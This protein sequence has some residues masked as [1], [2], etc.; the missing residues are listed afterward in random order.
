MIRLT[1][2]QRLFL[3][4]LLN[5]YRETDHPVRYTE[6]AEKLGVNPVTAYE[7]LRLL[8]EKGLVTS[9]YIRPSGHLGRSILVFRPTEKAEELFNRLAGEAGSEGEWEK[10]KESILRA[11]EEG[12]GTNYEDL[13]DQI[14]L[15]IPECKSPLLYT[16][17]MVTA[18]ILMLYRIRDTAAARGIFPYLRWLGPPGWI[19]LHTLAGLSLGLSMAEKVNR[20]F[21]SK[22][23]SYSQ[24]FQ[25]HLDM[26]TG[27]EK[28]CLSDFAGEILRTLGLIPYQ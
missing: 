1:A 10:V 18:I 4:K 7:M 25:E 13:L 8:E 26:L 3:S 19:M 6:V 27:D 21:A 17:D 11:L 15:R 9:E 14:L 12:R 28:R 20:R 23:L 24:Q 2:R 5:L 16:A 22:L